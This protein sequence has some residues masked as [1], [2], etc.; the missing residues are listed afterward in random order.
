MKILI[1][2]ANGYLGARLAEYL[3]RK[4][5]KLA[6]RNSDMPWYKRLLV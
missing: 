2:G 4:E 3:A 5:H 1:T 6:L